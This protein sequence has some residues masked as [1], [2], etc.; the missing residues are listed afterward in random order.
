MKRPPA[1]IRRC[2]TLRILLG[3]TVLLAAAS[4]ILGILF[5]Q[6]LAHEF[7][8]SL[9]ARADALVSLIVLDRNLLDFDFNVDAMPEFDL[10]DDGEDGEATEYFELRL[11]DGRRLRASPSMGR[12]PLPR[13][14]GEPLD[15]EPVFWTQRLPNG[16]PGRFLRFEFTPAPEAEEEMDEEIVPDE[17]HIEL[18]PDVDP[19]SLRVVL[20]MGRDR[21]D[22]LET[23]WWMY[24]SLG[25][26]VIIALAGIPWILRR[27]FSRGF[28]PVRDLNAQLLAIGPDS[29]GERVSLD[30]PWDELCSIERAVNRLLERVEAGFERERRFSSN[31][32]HELRTPVSEL[33]SAC[34]V[35]SRWPDDPEELRV[36]FEDIRSV[37]LHM[38]KIVVA[39]LTLARCETGSIPVERESFDLAP[40]LRNCWQRVADEAAEKGIDVEFALGVD[41]SIESDRSKLEMILQNVIENAVAHGARGTT[42]H[43][44]AEKTAGGPVV[45]VANRPADLEPGDMPRIF[46]RCWQKNPSETGRQR[47]GLGLSIAGALA[48]LLDMRIDPRLTEDGMFEVRIAG[49]ADR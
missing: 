3:T 18:P 34:E 23:V 28:R 17:D 40:M 47:T 6:R 13:F 35:G 26:F 8:E 22:F 7:D 15:D 48:G 1:S 32:A 49:E 4:A 33:R 25:A 10:P 9:E 39:L 24:G 11:P 31:V 41:L 16:Q 44:R 20:V 12:D 5:H 21:R 14:A 42:V 45:T 29:L 27:A 36:L 37:G 2:M 38:E 30:R 19:S 43:C 46:E